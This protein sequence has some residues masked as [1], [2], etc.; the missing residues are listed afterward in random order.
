MMTERTSPAR[1]G[2]DGIGMPAVAWQEDAR[3]FAAAGR[4]GL[5]SLRSAARGS[6]RGEGSE[7]NSSFG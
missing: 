5:A 6:G 2:R 1:A 3:G 7:L 4:G